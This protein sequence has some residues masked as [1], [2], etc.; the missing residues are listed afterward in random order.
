MKSNDGR[1]PSRWIYVT[2][3]SMVEDYDHYKYFM[4][5]FGSI[6][7]GRNN[8]LCIRNKKQPDEWLSTAG[9]AFALMMIDNYLT[10][11]IEEAGE[12]KIKKEEA[13][14]E[15]NMKKGGV[16]GAKGRWTIERSSK[17]WMKKDGLARYQDLYDRVLEA[18]KNK[19]R[20]ENSKRYWRSKMTCNAITFIKKDASKR[21]ISLKFEEDNVV[22][23]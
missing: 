2:P 19:S 5:H 21:R 10:R 8:F 20:R 12:G 1:Y 16:K 3:E 6:M 11:A 17:N 4:D 14:Q 7:V 23:W 13:Q 22:V 18:R 15:G 9:E